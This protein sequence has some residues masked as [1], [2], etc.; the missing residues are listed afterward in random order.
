MDVGVFRYV[1]IYVCVC[2]VCT[3]VL[4]LSRISLEG[5]RRTCGCLWGRKRSFWKAKEGTRFTVYCIEFCTC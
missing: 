2:T 5:D 3:H 4:Y 1:C